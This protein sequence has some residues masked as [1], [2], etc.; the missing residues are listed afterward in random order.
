MMI[1]QGVIE[2]DCVYS[3]KINEN[4]DDIDGSGVEDVMM[5]LFLK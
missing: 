2:L 4:V 5:F 1:I 3:G